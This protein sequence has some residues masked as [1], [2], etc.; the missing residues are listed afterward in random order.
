MIDG[1]ATVC[2]WPSLDFG[3]DWY[4]VSLP[5]KSIHWYIPVGSGSLLKGDH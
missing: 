4:R 2:C 1:I 5:L 3:L